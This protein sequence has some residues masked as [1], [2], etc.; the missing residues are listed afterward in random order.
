[1]TCFSVDGGE[2][3]SRSVVALSL[4]YPDS[5][6]G[7][8]YAITLLAVFQFQRKS[9]RFLCNTMYIFGQLLVDLLT[10]TFRTPEL[11]C[12]QFRFPVTYLSAI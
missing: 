6:K 3:A 1:M 4:L 5:I 8:D 10:P 9:F 7:L 2:C 11:Q 12:N